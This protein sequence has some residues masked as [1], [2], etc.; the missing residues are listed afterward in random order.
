MRQVARHEGAGRRAPRRGAP[1]PAPR[2]PDGVRAVLTLQAMAGNAAVSQVLQRAPAHHKAASPDAALLTLHL[3]A[4]VGSSGRAYTP[5]DVEGLAPADAT[6]FRRL[7]QALWDRRFGAPDGR[8]DEEE[9]ESDLVYVRTVLPMVMGEIALD[10]EGPRVASQVQAALAQRASAVTENAMMERAYRDADLEQKLNSIEMADERAAVLAMLQ[11][12][13][14]SYGKFKDLVESAAAVATG[15]ERVGAVLK[16]AHTGLDAASKV[17]K[18]VDPESYR[19]AVK[20]A[21]EWCEEHHAGA[22]LGTIRGLQLEGEFIELTLG[23]VTTVASTLS[24]AALWAL[25]ADAEALKMLDELAEAGELV[26]SAGKAAVKIAHV[27]EKL[28]KFE[29]V[30]NAIGVASGV[31]KLVTADTGAERVDAA[32]SIGTGA[33]SIAGKVTGRA[34]LGSAASSVLMTWEMVK[35]FG[36][37]GAGAI[38]GSMYGGLRQELAELRPVA[39][40]V[41]LAL[42]PLDRALAEQDRRFGETMASPEK[43]GSEEAVGTLAYRLQK[44]LV[45]ADRRWQTSSIA[46]LARWYPNDVRVSVATSLQPD[47]PP[48]IVLQSGEEF[49][50]ALADAYHNVPAIVV[51][52]LVDQGFMTQEQAGRQLRKMAEK[53]KEAAGEKRE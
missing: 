1:A 53:Q 2:H 48:S 39:D 28:E 38:E 29:T 19:T 52:M 22:G 25:K 40:R 51:G 49:V 35:F 23:T 13:W 17:A 14:G 43:T 27:L 50:R 11:K 16:G 44:A 7:Y 8:L 5:A 4:L 37:M 18:A 6:F 42:V 46:A 36:D 33:L 21:R 9:R 30:L 10:P 32:V 34:A 3:S 20:E 47:Y 26:G 12:G 45:E 15:S 31:A 24:K 41:A